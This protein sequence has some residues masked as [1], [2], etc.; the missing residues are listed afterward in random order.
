MTHGGTW[1]VSLACLLVAATPFDLARGAERA[2][3]ETQ[4]SV[5]TGPVWPSP[6]EPARIRFAKSVDGASAWGITRS[7][8]GRVADKLTG[9]QETPFVRP[10][11]VAVD[12]GVLYV[13][14][15]G[16]QCLVVLDASRR[17]ELR[18]TRVADRMLVSPVAVAPGPQGTVYLAD[19]RLREV[20]QLDRDGKLVRVVSH[21][22]LQRPSSVVFDAA[23]RRLYVGDSKAH[24][25]HVFD[26]QGAKVATLGSLGGGPGQFNSPTHLALTPQGDLAVTDALNYRVQ[27]FDADGQYRSQTGKVGDGA[28]NFAAPKGVA[29]DRQG[30]IYVADAMFDAVQIFDAEGRLL[31]GFGEQGQQAGQFW[32]PNGLYIDEQQRLYVA[33]AYNRRIQVFQILS[34]AAEPEVDRGAGQ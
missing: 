3:K 31:L 7:W 28:G 25:V 22:D 16:A 1:M 5:V 33:D 8:W 11:G 12:D 17:T 32:I 19:S 9:R 30:H 23:R 6:P 2:A 4:P 20:L 18:V 34:P 14:D 24:V 10:T 13:A 26:E 21:A 29:V 27:V 15:P